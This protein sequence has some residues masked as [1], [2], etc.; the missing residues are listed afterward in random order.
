[1]WPTRPT[2]ECH[3]M[4]RRTD[5]RRVSVATGSGH[6]FHSDSSSCWVSRGCASDLTPLEHWLWFLNDSAGLGSEAYL[7]LCS[8]VYTCASAFRLSTVLFDFESSICFLLSHGVSRYDVYLL[9]ESWVKYSYL[10]SGR[11]RL[12]DSQQVQSELDGPGQFVLSSSLYF[13]MY[14]RSEVEYVDMD[15]DRRKARPSGMT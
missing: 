11:C 1:M 13:S 8:D 12:S 5:F 3:S 15:G 2:C 9:W 10:S 6:Y 4:G 14:R 7:R